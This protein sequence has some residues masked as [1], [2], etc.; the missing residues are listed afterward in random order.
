MAITPV[1]NRA[2]EELGAITLLVP[3]FLFCVIA[4]RIRFFAHVIPRDDD[5]FVWRHHIRMH[6][7]P[8]FGKGGIQFL[9]YLLGLVADLTEG[10]AAA[11]SEADGSEVLIKELVDRLGA[12]LQ[13]VVS[14]DVADQAGI[15]PGD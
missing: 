7:D 2:L 13:I 9:H 5:H 15:Q 4:S 1:R 12:K 3:A 14:K 6:R 11:I 8:A 10:V